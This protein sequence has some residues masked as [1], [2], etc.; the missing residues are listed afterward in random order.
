VS[1]PVASPPARPEA[2]PGGD[3]DALAA[4]L[5]AIRDEVLASLGADDAA[6]IRRVVRR[7]RRLEL[8]GRAA[9]LL[10]R[11]PAAWA[12]GV[13]LLGVSKI[14]ENMEIGHNVMHGQWDWMRDP[15]INSAAWEWDNVCPAA[16]WKHTHNHI[17]HQWTN[18]RGRDGDIGFGVMRVDEGEPWTPAR[19]WQPLTFVGL[20]LVFEY[21]VAFH[22]SIDPHPDP[23][24]APGA[25][26]RSHAAVLAKVRRQAVRDYVAWPALSLPFGPRAVLASAAGSL[27]ANVIRNVWSYAVIVCGHFPDGVSFFDE[28]DV[29]GESRSDWYRRQALGSVNFTGGRLMDLMSGNLDH[30]VEH[31]LFPDMPSNRHAQVAPRVR[32]VLERNGVAYNTASFRRQLGSVARR[33]VCLSRPS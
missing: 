6:Y 31:H 30:Q 3:S 15:D 26:G 1:A 24:T 4:E 29:V 32:E 21:G 7:Q 19:R 28:Q 20:A 11:H 2:A 13:G 9:L 5:D 23:A 33:V 27:A 8:A 25:E 12:T 18:V 16:R 22:T 10:G 14:I 17:H